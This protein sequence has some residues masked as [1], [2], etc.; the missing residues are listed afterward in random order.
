MSMLRINQQ[1]GNYRIRRVIGE[2]GMGVVY[3]AEDLELQ[4]RVAVKVIR[5]DISRT[6]GARER[7]LREARA[8]AAIKS[9]HIV[10]IYQVGVADD[11]PYFVME[12][13]EG[14][15]L[16]D[17]LASGKRLSWKQVLRLAEEM[18][19][20]LA[21]AH[22]KGLIHRDIKPANIFIEMPRGRVKILDFGL[23]R[24]LEKATQLTKSGAVMGTPH[25]MAPEQASGKKT[26]ER[27]DLFSLGVILYQMTTGDLPFQGES[28]YEVLMAIGMHTPPPVRQ[29]CPD[30]PPAL[31]R[32]IDALLAKERDHRPSRATEVLD[33]L[34]SI[35][36]DEPG[37][38]PPSVSRYRSDT[39]VHQRTP[40]SATP[41]STTQRME[42]TK[43]GP[44][45]GLLIGLTVA[46]FL[47]V[48]GVA[49]L[50]LL[51][52]GGEAPRKDDNP[53]AG[54]PVPNP[55]LD[56]PAREVEPAP[57]APPVANVPN[58]VEPPNQNVPNRVEPVIKPVEPPVKPVAVKPEITHSRFPDRPSIGDDV[59]NS[60]GMKFMWVPAG[61]FEM[62]TPGADAIE[63]ET[64]C[65]KRNITRAFWMSAFE[66]TQKEFERVMGFN[67]STK[68]GDDFPVT[69]VTYA[70]AL[71]FCSKMKAKT[72]LDYRLPTEAQW[73]YACRAGTR[74]AFSFGNDENGLPGYGWF[75][76]NS[77]DQLHP[78]GQKRGNPW[79]LYDLHGNAEEWCLDWYD[80]GFYARSPGNDPVCTDDT[81]SNRVRRGGSYSD[82]ADDCRSAYR[83]SSEPTKKADNLGFRVVFA[84]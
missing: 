35:G 64:P 48:G 24:P 4:R 8:M 12:L 76:D 10:T 49:L 53:I 81:R 9:D 68:K 83:Y 71:T 23:A 60:I 44:S 43:A 27:A 55:P 1:I 84:R 72:G 78:V 38:A 61:S 33:Q 25:Y 36:D 66:V 47:V 30:A 67:P 40:R 77:N 39:E 74:T 45:T 37:F 73:E 80:D 62:G 15:P 7:F 70:D 28:I 46:A 57:V 42:P 5:E 58:R 65:K 79:G 50:V 26:D 41:H 29:V 11:L 63:D 52:K 69:N 14:R 18:A 82:P 2:G 3:E 13:L 21:D 54:K 31:S 75:D 22:G 56:D 17:Y 6:P 19:Q 16:N 51:N 34:D 59:T 32:L 20:G